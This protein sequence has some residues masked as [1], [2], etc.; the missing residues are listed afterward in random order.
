MSSFVF[1]IGWQIDW[2]D[3]VLNN[4]RLQKNGKKLISTEIGSKTD[5]GIKG[6]GLKVYRFHSFVLPC[7]VLTGWVMILSA[8]R[9]C[10]DSPAANVADHQTL[11]LLSTNT[12]INKQALSLLLKP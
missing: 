6:L 7:H 2:G 5:L 10:G 9:W 4:E 11:S 3:L 1:F 8:A 12:I